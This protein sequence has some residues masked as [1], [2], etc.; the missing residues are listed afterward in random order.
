LIL[1]SAL[2]LNLALALNLA[3]NLALDFAL[4]PINEGKQILKEIVSMIVGLIK[5][6]L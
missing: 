6:N 5:K 3:L 4:A 2:N 1:L